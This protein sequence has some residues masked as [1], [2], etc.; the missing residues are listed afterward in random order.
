MHF[1]TGACRVGLQ[2]ESF[3]LPSNEAVISWVY[4][5]S[6]MT[7]E[8]R[9]NGSGRER[10]T[11]RRKFLQAPLSSWEILHGP[12]RYGTQAS[13]VEGRRLTSCAMVRPLLQS[14]RYE[15]LFKTVVPTEGNICYRCRAC[16][17]QQLPVIRDEHLCGR[18]TWT[19]VLETWRVRLDVCCG[20][21]VRRRTLC[22]LRRNF[23]QLIPN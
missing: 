4:I 13:A 19:A 16:V 1:V 11:A 21:A 22:Q 20:T 9:W 6:W 12:D 18:V 5:R 14:L 10:V 8:H 23:C 7:V 3:Q 15:I 2:L 17:T